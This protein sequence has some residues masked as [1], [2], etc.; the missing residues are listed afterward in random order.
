MRCTDSVFKMSYQCTTG[1]LWTCLTPK[2]KSMKLM[3]GI[4]AEALN[5]KRKG[6]GRVEF[7][8]LRQEI[9][10]ALNDGY[11]VKE[12]WQYLKDKGVISIQ[13]R[14]FIRYVN[15]FLKSNE[16]LNSPLSKESQV[17]IE[18]TSL[19]QPI[20]TTEKPHKR[21]EFDPLSK[22]EEELI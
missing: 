9:Q 22:S 2:R 1:A 7:L 6:S 17:Q 8:A 20:Q 13:Y 15:R 5:Q 11:L 4:K 18:S 16:T 14:M 21:F 19:Q 10:D 3:D 12:V